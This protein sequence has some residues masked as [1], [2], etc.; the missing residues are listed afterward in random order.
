MSTILPFEKRPRT[1]LPPRRPLPVSF[2]QAGHAAYTRVLDKLDALIVD[3]PFAASTCSS[4][5]SGGSPTMTNRTGRVVATASLVRAS[6]PL[7]RAN[8]RTLLGLSGRYLD[9][10]ATRRPA[11]CGASFTVFAG[12]ADLTLVLIDA[13][14]GSEYRAGHQ[15]ETDDDEQKMFHHWSSS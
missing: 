6:R 10:F 11:V 15:H 4:R 1:S 5:L 8:T 9:P 12:H 3:N 14:F 13:V 2:S 7:T